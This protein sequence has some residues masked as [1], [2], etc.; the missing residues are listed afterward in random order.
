MKKNLSLLLA[1]LLVAGCASGGSTAAGGSGTSTT[2][3]TTSEDAVYVFTS[4]LKTTDYLISQ[5]ASDHEIN[6]N[7]VDGLLENDSKGKYIADLAETWEHNDDSTVWTFHI[8]KGV[9]WV[10]NTG[11][12]Y[13]EVKAQDWVSGLQHAA[14]FQSET[15]SLVKGSIVGLADYMD[16]KATWD[17]VGVKATDD[18]T[19]VYTLAAPEPY[20]DTKTTYS[21]LFPVNQEFLE[22]KGTGCKLGS[23]DPN[24]CHFGDASKFDSIL[25]NGGYILTSNVSKSEQK[26]TK[27]ENYWDAEHVYIQNVTR[28]YDDGSDPNST[29]TGFE[30]NN[31]YQGMLMA[32]GDNFAQ[33]METYKANAFSG[34]QNTY[35]FGVN[36]NLNRI[37]YTHTTKTE[38]QQADTRA[39]LLN[40]NF[41]LALKFGFDRVS[42]MAAYLDKSIAAK[43]IR[44]EECPYKFVQTSTGEAYGSLVTKAS[45]LG[46]STEE[47]QDPYYDPKTAMDYMNKAMTELKAE[48]ADISFPIILDLM[49]DQ[50][51]KSRSAQAS[52]MK[53]SIE[54]SLGG[55]VEINLV[56]VDVDTYEGSSYLAEGP[57]DCDWDISTSTGWGADYS[58]PK[59]YLNIFSINNGDV[60]RTS[61]G[62]EYEADGDAQ[63]NAAIEKSGMKQYQALL[64]AADA[65]TDD[66]DKRYE[67]Y[68]K[69]EA[70]LLDN[71]L[72]VPVQT[73]GGAVNYRVSRVVPFTRSYAIAGISSYKFKN[74]IIQKD[75]ITADE[76]EKAYK[77]WLG[78]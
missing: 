30:N 33:Y 63:N 15:I 77:A 10:T 54:A 25:Y 5:N 21:I 41:R 71:A 19:L 62:L 51:D 17:Q 66:L 76:Y 36:W 6:S 68:A 26:L 61:M 7:L 20:F 23:P 2:G 48:K 22:S 16:G 65:I 29:I 69:A 49:V 56:Y 58:D 60:I 47:G 75:P 38:A 46:K 74:M 9:N 31:F 40:T 50:T 28:V 11:E 45:T 57:K 55:N 52:S 42:Y 32:S 39:A 78:E 1:L 70:Y 18:Y 35:T 4:D 3:G 27:N 14:D 67:A 53:Q 24:N 72:F 34:M 73:Q 64:D 44:N 59:T 37:N 8:R 13:A 43:A 12:V